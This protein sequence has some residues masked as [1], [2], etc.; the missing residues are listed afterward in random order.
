MSFFS[1][2][3]IEFLRRSS[4]NG[5]SAEIAGEVDAETEQTDGFNHRP[6]EGVVV[7]A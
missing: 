1:L 4:V 7:N 3:F 5:D 6:L 2:F